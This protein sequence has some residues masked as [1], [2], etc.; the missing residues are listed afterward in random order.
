LPDLPTIYGNVHA[1]ASEGLAKLVA[2]GPAASTTSSTAAATNPAEAA[3]PATGA[4]PAA[5]RIPIRRVALVI[6]NGAYKTRPLDNPVNDATALAQTLK[7]QLKF[8]SV[9][10]RTNLTRAKM[11]EEL[12]EF[13]TEAMG[14]DVA[15]VFYAGHGSELPGRENYLIP[16]DARLAREADLEDEAISLASVQ[17][18]V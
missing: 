15:L 9:R 14:A 3:A 10:L 4:R 18:R 6:G 13:Q 12:Q 7:D 8:D 2:T 1:L 11:V 17:N 16:I 5:Q